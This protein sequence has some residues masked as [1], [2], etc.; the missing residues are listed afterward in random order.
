MNGCPVKAYEKDPVT[1]IVAPPRRPV[2]RL[3]VLHADV[4]VRGAEVQQEARHRAQVRHVHRSAGGRR[5]AGVRA[6]VPERGDRDPDRRQDAARWRTRRRA[7]SCP[8]RRRR[9]S[10]FRRRNTSPSGRCPRNLLP[11]DFYQVRAGHQHTAAGVD[12]GADPAL[13]RRVR[14]RVLLRRMA[15]TFGWSSGLEPAHRDARA[16]GAGRRVAGAGGQHLPPGPPQ[17]RVSRRAGAAHIVDEPRDP[18]VRRCSPAARRC[19]RRSRGGRRLRLAALTHASGAAVQRSHG[20]RAG[21]RRGRQRSG[22][23]VLL[24]DDLRRRPRASGG[25]GRARRSRSSPARRCWALATTIFVAW[26]RSAAA[27]R[28]RATRSSGWRRCWCSRPRRSCAGRSPSSRHLADKQLGPLRRTALL[29]KG[30][31]RERARRA[32]GAGAR[33]RV[34]GAAAARRIREGPGARRWAGW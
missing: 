12:A 27:T 10:R 8:A 25:A 26:P 32:P 6:G 17:V 22:R 3:P 21:R 14:R 34:S 5:G 9:A 1:G 4:P 30:D 29:L 31:L 19:T 18:G 16:G 24:R 2:H 13:G 15:P 7:A 11:A 20:A 28:P 33:G 23:R